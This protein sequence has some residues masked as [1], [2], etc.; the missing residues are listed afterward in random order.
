[1]YGLH[2]QPKKK[3]IVTENTIK[4]FMKECQAFLPD[5][6][7]NSGVVHLFYEDFVKRFRRTAPDVWQMIKLQI[8]ETKENYVNYG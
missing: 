7:I 1:M 8:R 4:T 5:D 6:P 2:K 3:L